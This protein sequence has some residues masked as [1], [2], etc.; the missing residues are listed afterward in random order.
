MNAPG[1]K[2]IRVVRVAARDVRDLRHRVLWPN[3]ARPEDCV[4]DIDESP[5]AIHLGAFISND[6]SWGI[7]IPGMEGAMVGA[8]SLFHQHCTR[9]SVPWGEGEDVRLRVMGTLPE[10]RGW[11]A[12]AALIAQAAEE[13]RLAGRSVLWCDA[14]E[15][16]FG[17]YERMGFG[18]LNEVYDIPEIG[19]HRTMALDVSSLPH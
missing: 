10:V 15:V 2:T 16:A 19:P 5:E 18:Y 14:R 11:G 4:I 1:P 12:G 6:E 9:T 17:F 3:K 7:Q 8:C 13:V